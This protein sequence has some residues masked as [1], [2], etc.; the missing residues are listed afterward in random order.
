M[1]NKE[2]NPMVGIGIAAVVVI[3]ILV[4]GYKMFLAPSPADDPSTRYPGGH[5]PSSSAPATP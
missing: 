2:I 1:N 3:I 4:I 5:P